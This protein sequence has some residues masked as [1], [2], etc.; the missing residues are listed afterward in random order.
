L[1]SH[2]SDR[3]FGVLLRVAFAFEPI[4]PPAITYFVS[5]RLNQMKQQ[6]LISAYKAKTRRLGK[7]HYRV[8]VDLDLTGKQAFHVIDDLL[9]SQIKHLRR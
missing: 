4:A 6:G 5:R 9:P 7:F 1:A 8:E 3:L 2:V